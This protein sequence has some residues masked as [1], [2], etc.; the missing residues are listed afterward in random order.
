M[1]P[2]HKRH[3][4]RLFIYDL[5]EMLTLFFLGIMAM[6]FTFTLGLHFGKRINGF[7]QFA[8]GQESPFAKS[9]ADSIPDKE[10]FFVDN[11]GRREIHEVLE[12]VLTE[13]LHEEVARS[14]LRL[15]SPQIIDLPAQP[16]NTNE[17]ATTLVV[18]DPG[19]TRA[20]G[21][22]AIAKAAAEAAPKSTEKTSTKT[23][24]PAAQAKAL[25][26]SAGE[27]YTLQIGAFHSE[28]E[29]KERIAALTNEEYQPVLRAVDLKE[30]GKWYRLYL[31]Q[32]STRYAAQKAGEE[33]HSQQL[34]DS[35]VIS[36]WVD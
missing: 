36:P 16:K 14:G 17:G 31:G 32:F 18:N 20:A 28:E 15:D 5:R 13:E 11:N 1:E 7:P 25:P 29:A 3:R 35:F 30:K 10:H 24:G 21:E 34:I 2:I 6:A 23:R 8:K 33:Y 26:N 22:A 12:D 4:Q 9:L 27:K 19:S